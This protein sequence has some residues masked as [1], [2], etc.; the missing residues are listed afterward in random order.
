MKQLARWLLPV[1]CVPSLFACSSS[2][3]DAATNSVYDAAGD[4][5]R[6]DGPSN[7]APD[8]SVPADGPE[9][10][11]QDDGSLADADQGDTTSPDAPSPSDAQAD[12]PQPACSTVPAVA[13]A[14]MGSHFDPAVFDPSWYLCHYPDLAA[15][16]FTGPAGA[17]LHWLTFGM[18]EGR[19]A[20]PAFWVAE[21][22]SLYP[23]L[24]A[25]FGG[26]Y[27]AAVLHFVH[28]G[29]QEGRLGTL[30]GVPNPAALVGQELRP[31]GSV[32]YDTSSRAANALID[33]GS[34][35]RMAGGIDHLGW[36]GVEFINAFDHGRELQVAWSADGYGECYNPTECGS[37]PDGTGATSSSALQAY[38]TS[39]SL[40]GSEVLP[41]FWLAPGVAYCGPVHNTTVTS[42]HVLN[43]IVRVGYGAIR[44]VLEF[45]VQVTIPEDL[46][47]LTIEAPTGYLKGS[48][49]SFYTIDPT[50]GILQPLS[51]GP[52]E[53]GLPVI[54]SIP[55]G[56][57]AMGV[58][59]PDLPSTDFPGT[60]YGRW[61]F[62]DA[63][64]P[65]N[66]TNKWNIV[67]RRGI[68]PAGIYDFHG[69]AIVGTLE[70]V[71]VAMTQLRAL[72]P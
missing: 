72:F 1:L 9:E 44:H 21:Y 57:A 40:L 43:K 32:S 3:A 13:S 22:L 64:N 17:R 47:S 8:A 26:D 4:T 48:F 46:A 61:A 35:A 24:A 51:A 45:M 54:L 68:T 6:L 28:H 71:R 70:N 25:A 34:S 38:W 15:A 69:F 30:A 66:A 18:K 42:N 62:P 7:D 10:A 39:G 16:G 41:A 49:T 19:Q 14:A 20:H 27:P 60:G 23:D 53:Q 63:N 65:A 50:T 37:S 36:N 29:L 11:I 58:W 12:A 55:D 67:F 31:Q 56:S 59:S 5:S 33:L 52:G 2:G